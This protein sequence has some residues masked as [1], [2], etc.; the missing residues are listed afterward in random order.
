MLVRTKQQLKRSLQNAGS[1]QEWLDAAKAYD[2]HTKQDLWRRKDHSTQYDYVSIR[3]RLDRLRSLK[4]RHD[5][6]GMLY[7][8]NEGIHGNLCG[9]GRAGLYGKA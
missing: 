1:Y 9:M 8:L 7:T 3:T 6:R 4:A 5:T 2:K